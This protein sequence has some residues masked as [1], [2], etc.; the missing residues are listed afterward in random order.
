MTWDHDLH[1]GRSVARYVGLDHREVGDWERGEVRVV[2]TGPVG[3]HL[4]NERGEVRTGALATM[5]DN[6]AGFTGGL[7]AMPDGWVVSANLM[8]RV[9]TLHVNG[10][11]RIESEVLR[12][13]RS[14]IVTSAEVFDDGNGGR[15]VADGVLTNAILVPEGGP[16][17]WE[18]P[19]HISPPELD[20]APPP[21]LEAYGIGAPGPNDAPNEV[22]LEI[23]DGLRNPWGIVHGGV[24]ATLVDVASERAVLA[25]AAA[26][27]QPAAHADTTDIVIHYLAP[28]RVG[29]L[30]AHVDVLGARADG[31]ACRVAV[32]DTGASDRAV[33]LAATTVRSG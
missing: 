20:S 11:I 27:G 2:G 17:P 7:A 19:A 28:A 12:K 3:S 5:C 32:T 22:L 9:A 33:A 18:R 24:T 30:R 31:F 26:A 4:H 25:A 1:A 10:P 6:V 13:G 21:I 15:R 16:P 29:P 23:T 14:A 8:V